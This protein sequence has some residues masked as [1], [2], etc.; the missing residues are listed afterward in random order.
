MGKILSVLGMVALGFSAS[1]AEAAVVIYSGYDLGASAPGV[2]TS[3]AQ[4][5]FLA[6]TGTTEIIDFEKPLSPNVSITGGT[7]R[8]TPPGNPQFWGSNVT[9]GGSFYLDFIGPVTFDFVAPISSFGLV[10]GGL[11]GPNTISWI[12]SLGSQQISVAQP[13]GSGF[14][15]LGFTDFGQSITSVT[16]SSPGDFD[17]LDDVRF[18][19][20]SASA[21]P[22][23][24]TWALML[25]GF[26][27]VG[28]V[29]RQGKQTKQTVRF[30]F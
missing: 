18:G 17:G 11:Q 29:L 6:A 12:N 14:A 2:N 21:V 10:M 23:P 8:S 22:E 5:S 1:S 9:P 24:M 19:F 26:G 16:V 20:S 4:S 15:F 13:G 30:S 7:V 28:A 25:I 3:S 27:F